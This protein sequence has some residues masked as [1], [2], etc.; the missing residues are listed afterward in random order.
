MPVVLGRA[1]LLAC[2]ADIT[3]AAPRSFIADI[4]IGAWSFAVAVGDLD[5]GTRASISR[6]TDHDRATEDSLAYLARDLGTARKGINA[7]RT[8]SRAISNKSVHVRLAT[9]ASLV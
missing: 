6:R 4:T 5:A 3:M 1:A 8:G 7:G 9:V 2:V